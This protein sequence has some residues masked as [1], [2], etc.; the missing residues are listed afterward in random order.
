MFHRPKDDARSA[1]DAEREEE[2]KQITQKEE[3]A[4]GP[5]P[6]RAQR[7][8][9]NKSADI[10]QMLSN[11]SQDDSN[12]PASPE[13]ER[14]TMNTNTPED[15]NEQN[16]DQRPVDVPASVQRQP[17]T[18]P[19][20][21]RIP[22]SY[23]TSAPGASYPGYGSA[24]AAPQ[25]QAQET[26]ST[27]RKLIVGE[28]ITMSGEIEAC[29]HL[30]VEGKVEAALK[31]A[32]LLDVAPAGVFYGTVEIDEA[33]IAGRFEGDLTVH[34]RLTIRS[35]GSITGAISYK[36]LA[37]EAGAT[38]DGKISPLRERTENRKPENKAEQKP[39]A[40]VK[41]EQAAEADEE[42]A[43]LPFEEKTAEAAE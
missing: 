23:A 10:Y 3:G 18:P 21:A 38:V 20:A 25:Q 11:A 7:T 29:D 19:G 24:P 40:K 17:Q 33:T 32:S 1:E 9:Q 16:N 2:R 37:V 42:E 26:H 22:G 39:A 27:G 5:D 41:K 15:R 36:E 12:F 31:G 34:G 13:K 14:V 4:S 43:G 35:T 30:I 8:P 6:D 28:G